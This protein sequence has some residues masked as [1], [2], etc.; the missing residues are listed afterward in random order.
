MS[1]IVYRLA[2][3]DA[4]IVAGV[5]DGQVWP[6]FEIGLQLLPLVI[7]ME[8]VVILVKVCFNKD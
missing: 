6:E 7:Q 4:G 1:I 3:S 2:G 8:E 5:A